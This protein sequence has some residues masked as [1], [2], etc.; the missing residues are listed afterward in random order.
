MPVFI[1]SNMLEMLLRYNQAVVGLDSFSTGQMSNDLL[2]EHRLEIAGVSAIDRD[3]CAG[4]VLHSL[5]D[6]SKA[7]R[8]PGYKFTHRTSEGMG[9]AMAWCTGYL[10]K[11]SSCKIC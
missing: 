4:D 7:R 3:F 5:A 11:I 1:G 6:I 2:A 8:L 10:L 9:E